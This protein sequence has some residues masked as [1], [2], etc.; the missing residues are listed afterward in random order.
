M[1]QS[2]K[3]KASAKPKTVE[4]TSKTASGAKKD[5]SSGQVKKE[6]WNEIESLFADKKKVKRELKEEATVKAKKQ[7][8]HIDKSRNDDN[9]AWKDDGLGGVYNAEGFTGRVEDGVK[10]FKAHLLN[11]PNAGQTPQCPF[12]CDCCFI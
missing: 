8:V 1:V 9:G 12:D 6:G 10:V 4:G 3:D 2:T 7:R 11:K 5:S